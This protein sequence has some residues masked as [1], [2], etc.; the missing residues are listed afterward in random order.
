MVKMKIEKSTTMSAQIVVG[1]TNVVYLS[2][3]L[4]TEGRSDSISQTIQ[5]KESYI[6]NKEEV[7]QKIS[8]F[9]EEVYKAQDI[10]SEGGTQA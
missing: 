3:T 2:A 7:R 4:S 8:E 10:I 6:S 9:Q 1:D 5:N